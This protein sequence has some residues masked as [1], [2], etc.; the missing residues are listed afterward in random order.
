MLSDFQY[1]L[2]NNLTVFIDGIERFDDFPIC[3]V[4]SH[5][6][7]HICELQSV[8]F[9]IS[10]FVLCQEVFAV[11]YKQNKIRIR[12]IVSDLLYLNRL[13]AWIEN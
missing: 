8:Q 12:Q 13:N 3:E 11:H 10:R 6:L 7:Q 1:H 4:E 5:G 9:P 2:C